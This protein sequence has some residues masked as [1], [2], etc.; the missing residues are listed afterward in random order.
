MAAVARA[1]AFF[2]E[3]GFVVV[4]VAGAGTTGGSCCSS[5]LLVLLLLR[6]FL[7][8]FAACRA[9]PRVGATAESVAALAGLLLLMIGMW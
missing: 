4:A 2:F 9:D 7:A 1:A 8:R 5:L 6:C 3:M